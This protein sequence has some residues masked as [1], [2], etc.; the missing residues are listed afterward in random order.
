MEL[1]DHLLVLVRRQLGRRIVLFRPAGAVGVR[2][3]EG[4]LGTGRKSLRVFLAGEDLHPAPQP[5]GKEQADGGVAF[6]DSAL[7]DGR[8]VAKEDLDSVSFGG[9]GGVDFLLDYNYRLLELGAVIGSVGVGISLR[10]S[11]RDSASKPRVATQELP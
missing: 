9:R 2:E 7:G 4:V 11:Q 10:E 3:S 8:L 6:L 5:L 1:S